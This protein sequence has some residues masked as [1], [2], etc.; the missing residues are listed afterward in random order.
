MTNGNLNKQKV[1]I[2]D[3]YIGKLYTWTGER[4]C[5]FFFSD[6]AGNGTCEDYA[7]MTDFMTALGSAPTFRD[8]A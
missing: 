8:V 2:G 6:E 5:R 1:F 4:H 7:S 3:F